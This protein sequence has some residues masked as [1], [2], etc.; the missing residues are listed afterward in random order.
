M[1]DEPIILQF[2][3]MNRDGYMD[4]LVMDYTSKSSIKP[5]YLENNG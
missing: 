4:L 3:D 5:V 2:G 1:D